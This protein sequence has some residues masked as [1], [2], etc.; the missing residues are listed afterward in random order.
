MESELRQADKE[1]INL[2]TM[3]S[4]CFFSQINYTV[5]FAFF[6]QFDVLFFIFPIKEKL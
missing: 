2:H 1:E 4:E 3:D 5:D 6:S